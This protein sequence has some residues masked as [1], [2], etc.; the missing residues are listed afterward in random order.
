MTPRGVV[1]GTGTNGAMGF[2]ERGGLLKR[3]DHELVDAM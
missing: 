2:G 1:R 3:W